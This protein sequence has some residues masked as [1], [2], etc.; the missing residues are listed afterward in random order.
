MSVLKL[1][2]DIVT[3]FQSVDSWNQIII[4]SLLIQHKF[5][6]NISFTSYNRD[7]LDDP[8]FIFAVIRLLPDLL[9]QQ[10]I[11]G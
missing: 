11:C 10:K 9:H 2:L 4:Q 6:I 8:D 5:L 3:M 1:Q 7:S